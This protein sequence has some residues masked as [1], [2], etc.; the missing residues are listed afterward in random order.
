MLVENFN[1]NYYKKELLNTGD[2][3]KIKNKLI[4][5]FK[6]PVGKIDDE[7]SIEQ[8]YNCLVNNLTD[9]TIF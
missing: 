4:D 2:Y 9:E 7:D 3:I 8:I 6:L 1:E 5:V